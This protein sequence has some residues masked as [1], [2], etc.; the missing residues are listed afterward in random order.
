MENSF[1]FET[2][3]NVQVQYAAAGLGTRFLSWFVDQVLI[4]ICMFGVFIFLACAGVS[5][6]VVLED[7][8]DP[9][10][11]TPEQAVTYILGFIILIMG[12][13]SFG[14]FT[15]CELLLRGQTPG[16]RMT[17]IRVVKADGFALDAGSIFMRNIFRVLDNVPLTWIIPVMSKRSQRTGDMVAGTLVISDE[18]PEMSHVRVQLSNRTAVEAEFRFDATAIKNLTAQDFE[19]VERLLERWNE[20]PEAQREDLAG[21]LVGSLAVKLKT[22]VPP[23]DRHARYLEDLLAAEIRR[24]N[25]LLG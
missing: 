2:P 4:A 11:T 22:D 24:Q 14:Y 16:K 21:K 3:E 15:A 8:F 5:L 13:G 6:N 18:T 12:F 25:R 9:E 10:S 19:A 23:T 1:Q 20:I 7:F 17:H